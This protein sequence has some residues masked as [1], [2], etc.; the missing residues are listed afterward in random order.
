MS[1][2]IL[3][4]HVPASGKTEQECF[5]KHVYIWWEPPESDCRPMDLENSG[6]CLYRKHS[7]N[8][9]SVTLCL[10]TV[11][12]IEHFPAYDLCALQV[13][14]YHVLFSLLGGAS[15]WGK[16]K[17][18]SESPSNIFC[19]WG[20]QLPYIFIEAVLLSCYSVQ[21]CYPCESCNFSNIFATVTLVKPF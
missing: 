12:Q 17:R 20:L 19:A 3:F 21:W 8:S 15:S 1:V 18:Q 6:T 7:H 5:C 10:L 9:I 11:P 2:F 4:R 13:L 14:H 16:R